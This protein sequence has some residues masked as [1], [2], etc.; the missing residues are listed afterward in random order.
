[1][2]RT[3][4]VYYLVVTTSAGMF[5]ATYYLYVYLDSQDLLE[6]LIFYGDISI[7]LLAGIAIWLNWATSPEVI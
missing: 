2:R 4:T 6:V 5:A 7:F 3:A 1:M